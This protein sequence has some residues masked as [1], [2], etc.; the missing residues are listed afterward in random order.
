MIMQQRNI[1]FLQVSYILREKS[2]LQVCGLQ[3]VVIEAY[4]GI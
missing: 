1:L 3:F 4:V 2:V